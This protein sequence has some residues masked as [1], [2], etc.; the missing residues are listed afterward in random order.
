ME[1]V[2][3]GDKGI[4]IFEGKYLNGIRIDQQNIFVQNFLFI[5]LQIKIFKF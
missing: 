3:Y 5:Y 1:W 2:N 4:L